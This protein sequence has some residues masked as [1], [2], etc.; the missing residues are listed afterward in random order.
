MLRKINWDALGI[1][2]SLIC[3]I[4]C[5]LV[6]LLFTSLPL[7]GTDLVKEK[8]FEYIMICLAF[9]IGVIALLHGYRKHHH[10]LFPI[11]IFTVGFIFLVAKEWKPE[12]EIPFLSIAVVF[13]L[14]AHYL[15][16]KF[17]RAHNHAHSDDCNH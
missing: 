8:T 13:I 3:A 10:K 14:T 15:N 9:V 4:H 2:T 12:I 16:Y 1:S 17:C 6:P 5:A 11:T 7:F